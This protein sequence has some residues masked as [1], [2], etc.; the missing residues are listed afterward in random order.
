MKSPDFLL[1]SVN[2]ALSYNANAFM[3]YT[4][5]PQSSLRV[6]IDKLKIQE[7]HKLMSENN[8]KLT[9]VII[10]APYIINLASVDPS[11]QNF[12]VDFLTKEL[13]R[14]RAIGAKYIVLH[15]GSSIKTTPAIAINNLS[16]N[17][18][19]VLNKT[20]DI[21]I[22]L[23]TMAGKGNEIGRDFFELKNIIKNIEQKER[24]GICFDTCHV[25]DA[26]YDLSNLDIVL[27]EYKKHLKFDLLKV[28]HLNDSING[29]NSHK[30]RHANINKGTI[31]LKTLIGLIKNIHFNKLPFILETPYIN[32]LPPYK[33][34]IDLILKNL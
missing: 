10:H 6:D 16:K 29:L 18:N 4:G 14:S 27:N 2:E 13:I 31:G 30:D 21:I 33:N 1:G 19:K 23:E 17:L 9:N 7:A 5:P 32:D 15:P 22:C 26:G 34:E 8:I 3:I 24:I 20:K 11:K 12:G 25:N 28:V